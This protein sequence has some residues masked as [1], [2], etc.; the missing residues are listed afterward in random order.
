MQLLWADEIAEKQHAELYDFYKCEWWTEG[1]SF[2]DMVAMLNG[3]DEVIGC[4]TSDGELIGFARV[5]SDYRFKALI[6]DVIVKQKYRGHGLGEAIIK[7][8]FA[9]EPLQQVQ[10]F[11]LY[12][13]DRLNKF[14]EKLGFQKSSSNLLIKKQS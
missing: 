3:S 2:E 1:R 7:R 6:F 12:C 4:C 13:P 9:L 10:S 8:I 11:E 14:Y 5:L